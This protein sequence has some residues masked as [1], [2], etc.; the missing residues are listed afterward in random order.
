MNVRMRVEVNLKS[1]FMERTSMVKILIISTL[2]MDVS[3]ED[4]DVFV[5]ITHR[6]DRAAQ[7]SN[8]MLVL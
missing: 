5:S 8:Y 3:M 2:K 4:V 1:F 7:A 6:V